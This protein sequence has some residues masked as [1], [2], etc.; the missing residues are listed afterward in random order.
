M[1]VDVAAAAAVADAV[2]LTAP[3]AVD[4]V[5]IAVV[6]M[7]KREDTAVQLEVPVPVP[8]PVPYAWF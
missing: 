5:D 2:V 4:Y 8:V 7:E 1:E 3:I 6:H